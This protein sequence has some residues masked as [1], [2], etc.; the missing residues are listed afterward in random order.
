MVRLFT[1]LLLFMSISAWGLPSPDELLNEANGLDWQD[2]IST[3][4]RIN[5]PVSVVWK[6]ASDSTKANDWSIYFDHIS[7]LPGIP[8][9]KIGA[10]RRCFR[11]KD[12]TGPYWDEV[13]TESVPETR[14]QITTYGLKNFPMNFVTSDQYVF[15]RQ[16]YKAVDA[17][18][19]E[20]TFQ[21]RTSPSRTW[22]GRLAFWI[23]KGET[24]RIFLANLENIK[25][26]IE[27]K[28]RLHPWEAD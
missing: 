6:Y 25:A 12:E 14:R 1:I 11:N 9:G 18:T 5:A 24:E 19:T 4:V 16:L 17:N 7:P 8:D 27:G 23:S 15:V 2:A 28:P 10:L 21:T 20:M 13:T 26:N 3:T 22:M